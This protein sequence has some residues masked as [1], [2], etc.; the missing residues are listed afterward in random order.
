MKIINSEDEVDEYALRHKI[1]L[2][3]SLKDWNEMYSL[4][5]KTGYYVHCGP[6]L[7]DLPFL[8][9]PKIPSKMVVDLT[10][11][12]IDHAE[13]LIRAYMEKEHGEE[14]K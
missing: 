7:P 12:T 9:V 1:F 14:G 4:Y 2:I 8:V 11:I 10:F 5:I 13:M 3:K 6:S